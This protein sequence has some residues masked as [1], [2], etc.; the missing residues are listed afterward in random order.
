MARIGFI[1]DVHIANHRKSGGPTQGGINDR[2]N[3]ILE[4]LAQVGTILDD[5][6]CDGLVIVGDLFDLDAPAPPILAA[7]MRVVLE[8]LVGKHGTKVVLIV[9]NHDQHSDQPNDN[10]LAPFKL[11]G[12]NVV[13]V[14]RPML[15]PVGDA[16][17]AC[18]P[19]RKGAAHEWFEEA[20]AQ[21]VAGAGK[22]ERLLAFHL[23]VEDSNTP[24]FL[25]GAHDAIKV[26]ALADA[27]AGHGITAAF[28]GNWHNPKRWSSDGIDLVQC[29]AFV[30]TG[31]DNPGL[32]YGY[33]SIYETG[34]GNLAVQQV[35]GPR[36]TTC[37]GVPTADTA[38]DGNTFLRVRIHD[39]KGVHAALEWLE[40]NAAGRGEVVLVPATA[41]TNAEETAPQLP[42]GASSVR[43]AIHRFVES[44][45]LAQDLR[46]DVVLGHVNEVMFSGRK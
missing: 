20:V 35:A 25:K 29:G 30:P 5:N 6:E 13:V 38:L 17:V 22:L 16:A 45:P 2:C 8:K 10:A 14:E 1:A 31:W 37:D 19:F 4:A 3:R 28:A 33:V 12:P 36:F 44:M 42:E 46:R 11:L 7:T 39:H 43:A 15:V 40:R 34:A 24:H 18:V 41:P 23:G 32:D 9:G 21:A 27:C 26:E